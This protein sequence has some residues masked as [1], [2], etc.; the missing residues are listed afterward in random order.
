[1]WQALLSKKL[2]VSVLGIVSVSVL[3]LAGRD[4]ELIK[5]AGGFIAGIV[6]TFNVSQ[7]FADGAS[8]GKTTAAENALRSKQPDA[9]NPE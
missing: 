4:I 6:S 9:R 7:G 1:M 2:I 3:V 8:R 5:W